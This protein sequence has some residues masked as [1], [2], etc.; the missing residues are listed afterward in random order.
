M[1]QLIATGLLFFLVVFGPIVLML[2]I[3][4]A[5]YSLSDNEIQMRIFGIRAL[6]I[7][8]NEVS[9]IRQGTKAWFLKS[10]WQNWRLN[11]AITIGLAIPRKGRKQIVITPPNKA[12]FFSRME[13]KLKPLGIEIKKD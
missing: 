2:G 6:T 9:W 3:S 8:Y 5:K 11:R 4:T 10:K 12:E 7:K 1:E 13:Q